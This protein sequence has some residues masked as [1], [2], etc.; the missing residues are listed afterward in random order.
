MSAVVPF[1]RIPNQSNLFLSYLE[2]SPEALSFYQRPP[3][4]A[5]LTELAGAYLTDVAFPRTE[6]TAILKRQNERFRSDVRSLQYI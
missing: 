2:L 1:A 6:I 5:A 3:T 4:L